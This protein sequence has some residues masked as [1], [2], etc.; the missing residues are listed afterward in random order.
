MAWCEPGQGCRQED[1]PH[2]GVAVGAVVVREP[3]GSPGDSIGRNDR[4][5]TFRVHGQDATGCVHQV[6][7]RMGL[8]RAG[9]PGRPQMH[10]S[11]WPYM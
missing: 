9:P 2:I 5:A 3:G 1:D 7:T 8:H 4:C 11:G 10:S 6:P